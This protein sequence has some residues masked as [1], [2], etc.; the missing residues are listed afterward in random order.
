MCTI[1]VS[2]NNQC[3]RLLQ[4]KLTPDLGYNR[5]CYMF[6]NNPAP[7]QI[8]GLVTDKLMSNN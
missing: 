5:I 1:G 2:V 6:R 8:V 7:V 4:V 3:D